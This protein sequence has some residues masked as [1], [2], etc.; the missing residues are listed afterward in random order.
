MLIDSNT[1]IYNTTKKPIEEGVL[2][3]C[4]KASKYEIDTEINF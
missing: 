3:I 2:E 1:A 4:K